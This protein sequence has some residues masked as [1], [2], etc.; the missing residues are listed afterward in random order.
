MRDDSPTKNPKVDEL[1]K[2][3]SSPLKIEM[4]AVREVM[5][6]SSSK[7]SEDIGWSAPSFFYKEDMCTFNPRA[8]NYITLIFHNSAFNTDA[9]GL[10]QGDS[11]QSRIARFYSLDDVKSKWKKLEKVVKVWV[12]PLTP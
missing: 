2:K 4:E 3:L 6:N 1:L 7:V 10:L 5:L 8:K 12:K 11:R 9:A